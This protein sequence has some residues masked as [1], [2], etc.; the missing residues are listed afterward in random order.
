[1]TE[2]KNYP[3]SAPVLQAIVDYLQTKPWGEVNALL[4]AIQQAVRQPEAPQED[5]K[6]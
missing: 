5:A 4:V 3:I 2:Q 1:M 6:L